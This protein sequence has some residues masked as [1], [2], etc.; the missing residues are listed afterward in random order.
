M[1]RG[2]NGRVLAPN[3]VVVENRHEH[4]FDDLGAVIRAKAL[5]GGRAALGVDVGQETSEDVR[6]VGL[7]LQETRPS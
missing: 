4:R 6:D 5:H 1:F 7:L 2:A 3:A